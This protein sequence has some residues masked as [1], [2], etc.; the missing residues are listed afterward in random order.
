MDLE[1][2]RTY[3]ESG[4][5]STCPTGP[6]GGYDGEIKQSW[7]D[8]FASLKPQSHIVDI[9]S[10]NGAVAI[11]AVEVSKKHGLSFTISGTDLAEIDPVKHVPSHKSMLQNINFYAG[12]SSETLPFQSE[13][14]DAITAQYGLEYSSLDACLTEFNRTLKPTGV[15]QFIMHHNESELVKRAV[16]S[17][18][19]SELI[20][21]QG[22]VL[23]LTEQL[24]SV[25]KQAAVV[26]KNN[27]LAVV[28]ELQSILVK[29]K[30]HD[31]GLLLSGVLDTVGY[32]L[33]QYDEQTTFPIKRIREFKSQ[34]SLSTTRL[35]DLLTRAKSFEQMQDIVQLANIKGFATIAL[36]PIYHRKVNLV[37]WL[38]QIK[39][40]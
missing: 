7:L 36:E 30:K 9:A 1:H 23:D 13:S 28:K 27:L 31:H 40:I 18:Y 37:G 6:D 3:H 10:G 4:M 38:W 35:N 25:D 19:E 2:W 14:I 12:V 16:G 17:I 8:F 21:A 5:L 32:F 20:L 39:K 34:I 29:R 26:I 15:C 24:F 22:S 33:Q 11:I